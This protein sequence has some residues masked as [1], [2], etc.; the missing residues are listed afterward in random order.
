MPLTASLF[1]PTSDLPN[2]GNPLSSDLLNSFPTVLYVSYTATIIALPITRP[3][4]TLYFSGSATV[5]YSLRDGNFQAYPPRYF[6]TSLYTTIHYT[7]YSSFVKHF[8]CSILSNKR[9]Q[10]PQFHATLSLV[11]LITVYSLTN[12]CYCGCKSQYS[13]TAACAC[14]SRC[15]VYSSN[16]ATICSDRKC[17]KNTACCEIDVSPLYV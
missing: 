13:L 12:D 9:A 15:T 2:V 11:L 17:F 3:M 5:R 8:A 7:H 10:Q 16:T 6:C 4:S 1:R 14:D